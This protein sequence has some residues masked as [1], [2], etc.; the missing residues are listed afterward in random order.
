[1]SEATLLRAGARPVVRLERHLPRPVDVVWEA[2]TDPTEMRAWFPTRIEIA[3]W[4]VGAPLTH[5]FDEHDIDPLPGVVLEWDPPRRVSFTW[6]DDTL[7]FEL[8]PRARR[9]HHLRTHRRAQRQPRGPQCGRLGRLSRPTPAR[10]GGR[11]MA[12]PFRTLRRRLRTRPR[13]AGR[14]TPGV[15]PSGRMTRTASSG[16]RPMRMPTS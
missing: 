16:S 14:P 10:R 12:A 6:A 7:S 3:E 8:A 1:M 15:P 4:K 2:V 5:Y 13:P 9:R 11:V